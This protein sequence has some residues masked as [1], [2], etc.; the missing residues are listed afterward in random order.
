MKKSIKTKEV[1]AAYM[2]V[3]NAKVEGMD[4]ALVMKLFRAGRAMHGVAHQFDED[5]RKIAEMFK[6]EGFDD[7]LAAWN[8]VARRKAVGID[9]GLPMT[10]QEYADFT[11][12]VLEPYNRKV[13]EHVKEYAEA[14]VEIDI[15]PWTDDEVSKVGTANKW[16]MGQI[17]ELAEILCNH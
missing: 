15:E 14:L 9:E 10:P 2:L 5:Q 7:K 4:D 3:S 1:F 6:P 11:Y 17:V 16:T 12:G 13:N 8:E